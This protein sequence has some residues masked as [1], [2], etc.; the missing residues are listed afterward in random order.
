MSGSDTSTRR[1]WEYAFNSLQEL[2]SSEMA[3]DEL[4][5]KVVSISLSIDDNHKLKLFTWMLD[6]LCDPTNDDDDDDN[7]N[8]NDTNLHKVLLELIPS[9]T[10]RD[11]EEKLIQGLK[12]YV[13]KKK[14]QGTQTATAILSITRML[15][16]ARTRFK[17][18][19]MLH[20][21]SWCTDIIKEKYEAEGCIHEIV[22]L[23]FSFMALL[24]DEADILGKL[25]AV[26]RS[27]DIRLYHDNEAVCRSILR[28]ITQVMISSLQYD[29]VRAAY[30]S[31]L[32]VTEPKDWNGLDSMIYVVL[33]HLYKDTRHKLLKLLH[34]DMIVKADDRCNMS[35]SMSTS[36]KTHCSSYILPLIITTMKQIDVSSFEMPMQSILIQAASDLG[37]HLLH[38]PIHHPQ[39]PP[40]D[41]FERELKV[42]LPIQL[43]MTRTKQYISDLFG[44]LPSENKD[45]MV[46]ALL[47]VSDTNI[48]IDEKEEKT[49]WSAKEE[50]MER[51]PLSIR[52]I[53][54]VGEV[55]D[56]SNPVQR[57]HW[58]DVCTSSAIILVGII[59]R[60]KV[61]FG[62]DI[63][64]GRLEAFGRKQWSG[65]RPKSDVSSTNNYHDFECAI[66][67][68]YCDALVA[69]AE[70]VESGQCTHDIDNIDLM[71]MIQR[72][73]LSFFDLDKPKRLNMVDRNGSVVLGMILA[74]CFVQSTMS[75]D[76]DCN[77]VVEWVTR[78]VV[79]QDDSEWLQLD[80]VT[81]YWGIWL[82]CSLC[83]EVDTSQFFSFGHTLIKNDDTKS[84]ACSLSVED[85]FDRIKVLALSRIG[86]VQ[87][88]STV[89]TNA[90]T[91]SV[92]GYTKTPR[93]FFQPT[94]KSK[95]R[96]TFCVASLCR[97]LNPN[98]T[99]SSSEIQEW[100]RFVGCLTGVYLKFAYVTSGKKWAADCWLLA[101]IELLP[102]TESD[103]IELSSNY[104]FVHSM[105]EVS[106]EMEDLEDIDS[107]STSVLFQSAYT[108]IIAIAVEHAVLMNC[109]S[110]FLK[111][112]A[113]TTKAE[114]LMRLIQYQLAKL[115][116]L[117]HHFHRIMEFVMDLNDQ[118]PVSIIEKP[119]PGCILSSD[120]FVILPVFIGRFQWDCKSRRAESVYFQR[121]P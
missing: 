31:V 48:E 67:E 39:Y 121:V 51:F 1:E 88:E 9:I 68:I 65:K 94:G 29:N 117:N 41:Y 42:Q 84:K 11:D 10:S 97:K 55:P 14:S 82:I 110:F 57:R 89:M 36:K 119:F 108:F 49:F 12:S 95:K 103:A 17:P 106:L 99:Q 37:L 85:V 96:L 70:N 34:K 23:Q 40:L 43:V 19:P 107:M 83:P 6:T 100:F 5:Q 116:D 80:A 24:D 90:T 109:Y 61:L 32:L 27:I 20:F 62:M 87:S 102:Y 3:E 53:I 81:G 60:Y 50:L 4:M 112:G 52:K 15:H 73:L 66:A 56:D 45:Q 113:K 69:Y 79:N 16:R 98:G 18:M 13:A 115:Y 74:K 91:E 35:M 72:M 76:E 7:D 44:I 30:Q 101:S 71:T 28:E 25:K 2:I 58:E 59:K 114:L 86:M 105:G 78:I 64:L 33:F 47:S 54:K 104:R 26:R 8:D 111:N 120:T 63:I 92:L 22:K 118:G 93:C 77:M 38:S 46:S 75:S 21:L